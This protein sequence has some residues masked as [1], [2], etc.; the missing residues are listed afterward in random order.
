M[1]ESSR[2]HIFVIGNIR[3]SLRKENL[4]IQK[5]R[6][7]YPR[8]K[9]ESPSPILIMMHK[10]TVKNWVLQIKLSLMRGRVFHSDGDTIMQPYH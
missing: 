1:S 3:S 10:N 4:S 8:S 2:C 6:G 5:M 7:K 9:V